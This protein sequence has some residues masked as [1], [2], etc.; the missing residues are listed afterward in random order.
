MK[1]ISKTDLEILRPLLKTPPLVERAGKWYF[2]NV[3]QD[4]RA[5]DSFDKIKLLFKKYPVF[6]YFLIKVVSPVYGN[7]APLRGFYSQVSGVVINIGSGN[8]MVGNGVFNLDIID[9][10]NVHLVSDIHDLPF[11]DNSLDAVVNIAVLEH[12]QEPS[13]VIM[14]LYRV[15]KP[16]GRVYSAIPF[17]QPFH[18]SPQDYQRYTLPGIKYLHKDFN[19]IEAGV[20]A[21]PFSGFLWVFQE[22]FA[23]VFSF[24]NP[25][26]RNILT[27][28]I[29]LL[30]WPI[31]YLDILF[32][33]LKTSP[34]LASVFYCIAEKTG[35]LPQKF[36]W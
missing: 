4:F 10:D 25:L 16:G 8:E 12:V 32:V 21:G 28:L 34:N 36:S 18:A 14:E 19:I 2:C 30:T 5:E 13:K 27:I 20:A 23:S 11:L 24:G 1:N 29:M 35:V 33:N 7:P 3:D 22:F 26:L 9:Y 31:K 17:M 6:Y 15:L